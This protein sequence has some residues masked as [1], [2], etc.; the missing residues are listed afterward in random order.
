[1]EPS[2][3]DPPP[4][5]AQLGLWD[6]ISIII[7]IVIGAGIYETPPLIFNNVSG[8]WQGLGVWALGGFL[9]LVGALC[10]AELA[11]TYPQSGGDYV[12]LTRAF[13]RWMGFLFG[14]AQLV[15]IRTGNIAMMAYVFA[16]YA[17]RLWDFGAGDPRRLPAA[18]V[19][20]LYA[21]TAVTVLAGLNILGIVL[22]KAT[23]N[24]LTA[25][26]VLGLSGILV[27]GFLAPATIAD[28]KPA[29]GS[30]S[31]GFALVLILYTYG[32]WN[33]AAMVAA[34]QRNPRRNIPRAL[35]L[36]TLSITLIYLLVNAAYLWCL[37]FDGVRQSSAVAAGVLK[38]ALGESGARAISLLVM[39]SALGSINGMTLAGSRIYSALGAENKLF[40]LL[41]RWNPRLGSPLWSLLTQLAITLA[42]LAAVGTAGGRAVIIGLLHG[43]GFQQVSWEGHGGFDTLLS[44]TAPVFWL[45]FLF[46]GFALFVLRV[47]DRW[48]L[49]PFPVP[50][51]PV[52]P[53]VFCASCAYMLYSAAA[54]AG[55]LA[56]L[57]AV[58]VL[59]GLI[60][61]WPSR[62]Q[63]V[64]KAE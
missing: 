50:L 20:F 46:T 64:P 18:Q 8:P 25:A 17:I 40:G 58:L 30:P 2:R 31:F 47:R 59:A 52:L 61:Y 10:Y 26:K 55:K 51:Y 63:E 15:V 60:L 1:M 42:L 36:G 57:P 48:T 56:L 43:L 22:G 13:G 7:G 16:D 19:T 29:L 12:Y 32:G 11:S 45:F 49:R 9:S 23:Q 28:G 41:G 27:A 4:V 6:A 35:I 39:I 44:W 34:E 24:T 37:G 33:D 53:L 54:Y 38:Q 3:N 14:W 21:I 5:Q 62:R